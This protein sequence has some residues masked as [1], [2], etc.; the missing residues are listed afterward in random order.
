MLH[1][2]LSTHHYDWHYVNKLH[3]Y[4]SIIYFLYPITK[5]TIHRNRKQV[6][7]SNT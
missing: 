4:I 7:R 3:N 1:I 6:Y 5:S 2:V